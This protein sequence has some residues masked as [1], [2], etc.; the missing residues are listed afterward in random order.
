M[1]YVKVFRS[2]V[3]LCQSDDEDVNCSEGKLID[4]DM[5]SMQSTLV[6][7]ARCGFQW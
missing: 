3:A 5:M 2:H 6:S 1:I 4:F 7:E